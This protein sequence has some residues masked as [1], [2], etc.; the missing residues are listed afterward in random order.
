MKGITQSVAFC[1]WPLLLSIVSS[2]SICTVACVSALFFFMVE[3][4]FLAWVRGSLEIHSSVH[5]C[6]V[7][8]C[9]SFLAL[10]SSASHSPL[11]L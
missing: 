10:V 11:C 6:W 8:A 1:V 7:G 3:S 5:G 9:F 2:R 4:S